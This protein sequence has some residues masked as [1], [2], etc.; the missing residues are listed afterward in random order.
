[1][2]TLSDEG[3]RRNYLNKVA[4]NRDIT[5]TWTAEAARRDRPLDVF[6]AHVPLTGNFSQQFQRVVEN[7]SRLAAE[8]DPDTLTDFIVDE[9][10]ELS[11]A[12]RALLLLLD[13][14]GNPRSAAFFN[15]EDSVQ[16]AL[17]MLDSIRNNRQALLRQDVGE[18]PEGEAQ[19]LHNR[20]LIALPLIAQGKMLGVLYGDMRQIFGRFDEADLHLLG[21]LANQSA[22]ALENAQLVYT[23]EERV[24][25]RTAEL[26]AANDELSTR[27]QELEII[28]SVQEALAAE[29]DLR[30][31]F[32]IVG[33]RLSDIYKGHSV[34]F[35]TYDEASGLMINHYTKESGQRIHLPP[36]QP[37]PIAR[38]VNKENRPILMRR[39]EEYEAMG[40]ITVEGTAPSLSG[41]YVPLSIGDRVFGHLN[42][43]H[44]EREEAY[45]ESDLRLLTTLANSMSVILENARLFDETQHLLGE[46]QQRNAELAAINA[47]QEGLVAELDLEAMYEVVGE[48]LRETYPNDGIVVRTYDEESNLVTDHYIIEEGERLVTKPYAPGPLMTYTRKTRKPLMVN[49]EEEF[50]ALGAVAI[51]G[52]KRPRSGIYVTLFA[53][54]HYTG[55]I[56]VYDLQNEHAYDASDLRLLTTLANSMSVALENAHLFDE[57]QSLLEET[58]RR[59]SELALINAVQEGL[60]AELNLQAIIEV[61]GEKLR[62][63]YAGDGVALDTY[64]AANDLIIPRYL[65]EDGR[66]L[67]VEPYTPGALNR[68]LIAGKKPI[69]IRSQVDFDAI[70]AQPIE[71]TIPVKSGMYV[72]LIAGDRY[73]GRVTVESLEKENA[74]KES[75]IRLLT[76]LASTMSVALENAR[77]FDETQNLLAQTEQRAAELAVINSVQ[78]TLASQLDMQAIYKLIG[79]QIYDI[80]D[81]QTVTIYTADE[82][83]ETASYVYAIENGR[84]LTLEDAKFGPG[85]RYVAREKRPL[86]LHNEAEIEDWYPDLEERRLPGEHTATRSWIQVPLLVGGKFIGGIN[87]ENERSGAFDDSDV[88]LLSTLAASM[89]VSLENARL[90]DETQRLLAETEQRAA[91]LAVVNTV[92]TALAAELEM[93]AILDLVGDK[94]VDLFDAQTVTINRFHHEEGINEYV[95]VI[96]EGERLTVESRPITPFYQHFID[97]GV[98]LIL[99]SGLEDLRA[100]GETETVAGKPTLSFINAPLKR[101]DR[102]TGYVSIQNVERE[103]A[104]DEGDLRLLSTL[105]GSLSVALENA[106]LFEETQRLLAETEQRAT[107]LAVINRVQRG[108]AAQLDPQAIIDLVGDEIVHIFNAQVVTINRLDHRR[109]LNE[110]SYLYEDGER[111]LIDPVPFLPLV[112]ELVRDGEPMLINTGLEDLRRRGAIKTVQGRPTQSMLA[113]P[114]KRGSLVIGYISIQDVERENVFSEADLRLL[115]TLAGSMSVAMESARLFDETQNLL[116]QTEQRNAELALINN[117]QAGL[118][119]QI[120]MQA[121]Y[122]LVGDKIYEIFEAQSVAITTIDYDRQLITGVYSIEKGHRYVKPT[123]PFGPG[124]IRFIDQKKPMHLRTR[125]E[126]LSVFP[127]WQ[128]EPMKGDDITRTMLLVPLIIGDKVFGAI[129]LQDSRPNLFKQSDQRLLTTLANSMSVA[130]ENARLFDETQRRAR[131]MSA[132]TEVG[133]DISSTLNLSDVLE[134]IAAHALELL[135]VSDSALFLPEETNRYVAGGP[136]MKGFVALGTIAEQVLATTV[137]PGIGILGHMWQSHEAEVVNDALSDPRAQTIVGTITHEDERMMATPL[138]SDDNVVGMMAVWR[139]GNPFDD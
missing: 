46:M 85:A 52:T 23:L 64:D 31:I 110:Y 60:A 25:E 66:R 38:Y 45:N 21:M 98:P 22:A 132:L 43:E 114:L 87:L 128:D 123:F 90:F 95:F 134:R 111:Q 82:E 127:D 40:T 136:T 49:T 54:D 18:V 19:E 103:N 51:E 83:N 93:Q 69:L 84:P 81:A 32:E 55:D 74:Y 35:D 118:A 138:L 42:I 67:T 126:L 30:S 48:K 137:R 99:N 14:G 75:D 97:E 101:G 24:E 1:I 77:L 121:I 61:V 91:E 7:G 56:A 63:I 124:S 107:E 119:A 80:F 33:E 8:H 41:M 78:S 53:G 36:F 105:A 3:L 12:E 71:G 89:S 100:R 20:S 44:I 9:F 102:I 76:T 88:R 57:T 130:L 6:T 59:N 34:S 125:E 27:N 109:R 79:D 113:A 5:L 47:V 112:E 104:F 68:L 58:K 131:E 70:G 2:A 62:E 4:V 15:P 129:D 72:P 106:R 115:S 39:R 133:S 17:Q 29:L 26:Q 28:N 37:G 120:D 16:L 96:E 92:Q 139:R 86:H 10:V 13:D 73:I 65:L 108:L 94:I 116:A 117:V 50:A 135:D 122:D 11:G